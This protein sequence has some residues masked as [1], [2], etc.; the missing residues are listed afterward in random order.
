MSNSDNPDVLLLKYY[1]NKGCDEGEYKGEYQN[2]KRHGEGVVIYENGDKHFGSWKDGK[3]HGE[4]NINYNDGT[5]FKGF[6]KDDKRSGDGVY[7]IEIHGT[8]KDIYNFTFKNDEVIGKCRVNYHNDCRWYNGEWKEGKRHG[9]GEEFYSYKEYSRMHMNPLSHSFSYIG[10]WKEGKRNGH[11]KQT[12]V[13]EGFSLN[14]YTYIGEWK[15]G[16]EHGKGKTYFEG[17]VFREGVWE[18]GKFKEDE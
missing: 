1:N 6:W 3:R 8:R 9:H 12:N 13:H 15:D 5:Q 4:G 2:G 7:I 18:N 16:K 10:E 17:N 11:G 14:N